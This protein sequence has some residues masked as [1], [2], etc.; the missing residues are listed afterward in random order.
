MSELQK[1]IK[2]CAMGFAAFLAFSIITGIITG[3]LALS[4]NFTGAGSGNTVN[5]TKS[6]E[7]VKSLSA[8]NGIGNF[9]IKVGYNDK[10]EVVAENVSDNFKVEKSFS[11]NLE[12][13][14]TFDFWNFFNRAGKQNGQAKVTIYI[15]KDLILENVEINAGAGNVNIEALS[16]KKLK[17]DAGAGNIDGKNIMA[18][19]VKLDGGVGEITLEQVDL[20]KVD[21]DCG[22]GNVNLQGIMNG[23]CKIDCG[24]GEVELKLKGSTDDYNLNIEKGLGSVY[25]NGEKYSDLNWNNITAP[26]SLDIDG[27]VGDI[28]IDFE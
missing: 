3:I 2:Y 6:F 4:G 7:D 9:T 10:I 13:K 18:S 1:V 14:S 23:K 21:I 26:N 25:I 12:V 11:G 20:T 22:V 16:T 17:I 24:V 8:D 15:P 19:E 27:G 5:V 28:D